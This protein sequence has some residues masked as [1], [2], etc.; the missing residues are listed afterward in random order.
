MPANVGM[1]IHRIK[2]ILSG[3]FFLRSHVMSDRAQ[4][5]GASVEISVERA[6]V[7]LEQ[8]VNRRTGGFCF[9]EHALGD[10]MSICAALLLVGVLAGR[11]RYG[12]DRVLNGWI[13]T[14]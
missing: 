7:K 8:I 3:R 4:I 14:R 9:F 12:R 10:P 13:R 5:P 1:K 6:P 11:L 2:N